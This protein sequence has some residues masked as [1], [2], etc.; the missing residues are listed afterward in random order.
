MLVLL[1]VVSVKLLM[2][3]TAEWVLV[4]TGGGTK[5]RRTRDVEILLTFY[6]TTTS[7]NYL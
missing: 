4:R 3:R 1:Y 6:F 7:L 5:Q 2:D